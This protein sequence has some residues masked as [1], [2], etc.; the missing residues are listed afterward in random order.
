MCCI[1]TLLDTPYLSRI[2]RRSKEGEN[3]YARDNWHT[4]AAAA[5]VGSFRGETDKA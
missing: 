1:E 5:V 3:E 4:A 2:W